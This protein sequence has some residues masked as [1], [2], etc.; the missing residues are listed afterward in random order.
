MLIITIT[1]ASVERGFLRQNFIKIYLRSSM[2]Q[3][4][5]S[6]LALLPMEKRIWKSKLWKNHW[7]FC[8]WKVYKNDVQTM[9]KCM[10]VIFCS[11]YCDCLFCW[12]NEN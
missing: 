12:S 9:L 2:S 7:R 5:L 1:L 10:T 4:R 11:V 3:E 6:G 8:G